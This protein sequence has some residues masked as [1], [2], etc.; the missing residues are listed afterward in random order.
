MHEDGFLSGLAARLL[1]AFSLVLAGLSPAFIASGPSLCAWSGGHDVMGAVSARKTWYFAE[2]CTRR[3]FEEWV[4][5]YNPNA[6]AVSA[7][8][9]Y[10]LGDGRVVAGEEVLPPRSRTTLNVRAV[11]PPDNDVSLSVVATGDIVA[12]RPMYFRY[13]NDITG[14]HNV[15]GAE[16]PRTAWFFA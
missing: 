2:G 3:G 16:A 1:L 9:S 8:C 14:G 5:L 10:M 12:E 11:I 15:M 13:H 4:C 7:T 6:E